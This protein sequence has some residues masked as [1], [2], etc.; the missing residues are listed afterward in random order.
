MA[1]GLLIAAS[2]SVLA[3]C[4]WFDPPK[5]VTA[6]AEVLAEQI[7]EI[8]GIAE[9]D[10]DVRDRDFKDHPNDWI[11]DF[12]ITA[13][14]AGSLDSVPAAVRTITRTASVYGVSVTLDVP[15]SRGLA[16]VVLGDLSEATV[17]A[18]DALRG[19]PEV[20]AVDIGASYSG[21]TVG[22]SPGATLA[23][24]AASLRT[25]PG[26]GA[27]TSLTGDDPIRSIT[28]QWE[29][30]RHDSLHTV[31][32]GVAGPSGPVLD[33]L[34]KLGADSSVD[35]V[36]ALEKGMLGLQPERPAIDVVMD[37]P[38]EGV[39][40]LAAIADPAAEAGTRPRTAFRVSTGTMG[41][42]PTAE[43]DGYVG[44]PI[45]SDQ[46]L[47]LPAPPAQP[48]PTTP[49]QALVDFPPDEWVPSTDPAVLAQ[50]D[51]LRGDVESFL[52]SA[53]ALSG[54]TADF[55]TGAGPCERPGGGTHITAYVVLPVFEIAESTDDAFA[56]IVAD[57]G[58]SG[59]A[60][61]DR[62][63]GMDIYSNPSADAVIASATIRGTGE[64]I[65]I[66][67]TSICVKAE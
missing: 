23:A 21:T 2:M 28:I 25:V 11:F 6:E 44:L 42:T 7:G 54:V 15:S 26:F 9:V 52:H 58:R 34:E 30:S 41:T 43:P 51:T 47:D 33:A 13:A 61:S 35:R 19:L 64:G 62:A 39:A 16:P 40:Q 67:V 55:T 4:S 5:E 37:H 53:E 49:D 46:P 66:G 63:L 14:D 65:N 24:T 1:A 29:G 60:R 22:K 8:N 17:R 20:A 57:W 38:A 59:L 56:A 12:S 31:E 45:G 27:D 18:A 48:D 50:L 3:G 32:V 10:V 36:Y